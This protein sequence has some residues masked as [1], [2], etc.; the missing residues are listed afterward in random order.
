MITSM[1]LGGIRMPKVAEAAIVPVASRSAPDARQ[2]VVELDQ[3]E[4]VDRPADEAEGKRGAPKTK[5]TG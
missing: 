2:D 1:M 5:A 4:V 3:R